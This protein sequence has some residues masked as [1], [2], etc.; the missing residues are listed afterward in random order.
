M[1]AVTATSKLVFNLKMT[2]LERITGHD[3]P[4]QEISEMMHFY[5]GKRCVVTLWEPG[6][7]WAH[8]LDAAQSSNPQVIHHFFRLLTLCLMTF[9][10]LQWML[11]RGL[12]QD[13]HPAHAGEVRENIIP[14][15]Q[16]LAL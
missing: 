7:E 9:T 14:C 5:R 8:I 12:R 13:H 15:E 4:R 16:F 1:D 2:S 10:Q 6:T 3:Y 11:E